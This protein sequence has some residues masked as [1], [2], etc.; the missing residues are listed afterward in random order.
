MIVAENITK[1]YTNGKTVT[2]VLKEVSLQIN[3]GEFVVILGASGSGKST[4][5]SVLSGLEKADSG[6]IT[7]G[8]EE[9]SEMT[10][11]QLTDFR[12]RTVG[13]VFQQYFLLP[14]LTVE[15]NVRLGANLANNQDYAKIIEAVGL[16]EKSRRRPAELS[17]GEQQ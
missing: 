6:K 9:L 5:L 1:S 15:G 8:G 2:P 13:F 14:H 12:K 3:D 4:L 17:G 7:V 11:K 10:D 16:G